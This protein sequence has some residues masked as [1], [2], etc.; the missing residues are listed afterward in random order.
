MKRGLCH[1]RRFC[2]I[3]K[4]KDL[5]KSTVRAYIYTARKFIEHSGEPTK[6][7]LKEYHEWLIVQQEST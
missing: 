7:P 6:A 2:K 3:L 1:D 5:S 4:K